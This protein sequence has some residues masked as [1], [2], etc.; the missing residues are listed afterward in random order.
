MNEQKTKVGRKKGGREEGKKQLY[1]RSVCKCAYV[2]SMTFFLYWLAVFLLVKYH[3]IK[4]PTDKSR[5]ILNYWSS[6]PNCLPK[7]NY[8]SLVKP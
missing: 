1:H 3:L 4:A 2:V 6:L 5:P 7:P 8:P